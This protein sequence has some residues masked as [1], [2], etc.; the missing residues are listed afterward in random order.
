MKRERK[1]AFNNILPVL[2]IEKCFET[3]IILRWSHKSKRCEIFC[4]EDTTVFRCC[5]DRSLP[6]II[7]SFKS[8][9]KDFYRTMIKPIAR[10]LLN[11]HVT[12]HCTKLNVLCMNCSEFEEKMRRKKFNE[13]R[14]RERE[15][16]KKKLRMKNTKL[17]YSPLDT[18][19]MRMKQTAKSCIHSGDYNPF[20]FGLV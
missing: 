13:Q 2:L 14:K 18:I 19:R 1:K 9:Y 8:N 10:L 11:K 6:E 17:H 15:S 3:V 4:V 20:M 12:F 5:F 16:E 7:C